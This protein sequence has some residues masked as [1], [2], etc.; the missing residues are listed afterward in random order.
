MNGR[1]RVI[2]SIISIEALLASIIGLFILTMPV[3]E[4]N[5]PGLR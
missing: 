4:G 5:A 2:N 1:N 3:V